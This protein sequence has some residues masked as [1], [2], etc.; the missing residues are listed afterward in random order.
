LL[1]ILQPHSQLFD[2]LIANRRILGEKTFRDFSLEIF[3]EFCKCGMGEYFIIE[4]FLQELLLGLGKHLPLSLMA[5][6]L[7]VDELLLELMFLLALEVL[8]LL[9]QRGQGLQILLLCLLLY[10]SDGLLFSC[11]VFVLQ[12]HLKLIAKL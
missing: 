5:D 2:L 12:F 9:L 10:T 3:L 6:L 8:E 4:V 11:L 7:Q 1:F